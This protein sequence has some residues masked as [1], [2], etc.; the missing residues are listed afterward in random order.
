MSTLS[1]DQR[2]SQT[3]MA[4]HLLIQVSTQRRHRL[5]TSTSCL[6]A[7]RTLVAYPCSVGAHAQVHR[8]H[9][10]HVPP[11]LVQ[12][13]HHLNPPTHPPA[14]PPTHTCCDAGVAYSFIPAD[15]SNG[16]Y[17]INYAKVPGA[18]AGAQCIRQAG[19]LAWGA[20]SG[21]D[22]HYPSMRVL[23]AVETS[24]GVN[25]TWEDN[26]NAATWINV[27]H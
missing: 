15:G 16:N 4:C 27:F 11:P 24:W 23:S 14:H 21:I 6:A 5:G 12:L 1:Q 3:A 2:A 22:I 9:T 10:P 19:N 17:Q 26:S 25:A 18:E 8:C 7:A 20:Y 13:P